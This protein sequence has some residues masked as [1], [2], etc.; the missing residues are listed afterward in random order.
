MTFDELLRFVWRALAAHTLGVVSVLALF[1][2]LVLRGGSRRR[3][4]SKRWMSLSVGGGASVSC[5][6]PLDSYCSCS[7]S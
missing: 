3:P 6:E 2:A 4:W 5:S 7:L 1:I